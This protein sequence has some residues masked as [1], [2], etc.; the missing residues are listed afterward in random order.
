MHPTPLDADL[1]QRTGAP[2]STPTA[3]RSVTVL[4]VLLGVAIA[5]SVVHYV[6]NTVRYDDY[7]QGV[8]TPV[9]RW[10]VPAG[11]ILFTAAGVAGLLLYERGRDGPAAALL[12]FYSVS[13]LIG[14]AHYQSISPT[15]FDALQNT[16]IVLDIACGAS[17]LAFA[18]WT[19]VRR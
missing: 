16:F 6:D 10:M 1:D 17:I 19:A 2:P 7:V 11:W 8:S 15:D 9:A 18:I 5:V 14:F 4:R 13:G 3:D 12:A